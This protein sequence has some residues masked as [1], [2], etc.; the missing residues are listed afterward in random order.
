MTL[1]GTNSYLI[2]CGNGEAVCI[3]PGPADS[4]HVS[5]IV[6]R[7]QRM[8]CRIRTIA[9]THGH[10]DHAPAAP[11]LQSWTGASL[12]TGLHPI[13]AGDAVLEVA[14]AP[15]H[16]ADHVVYY[17]AREA[18]LFTGDTVLGTGYVVVAP[19]GGDMRAYQQTLEML[20]ERFEQAR[21]IYPGHGEP[22]HDPAGKLADYI[23]HRKKRERQI[24]DVL[25]QGPCTIPEIVET[26]YSDTAEVLWPVAA[27]QVLAYLIALQRESNVQ[28][29]ALDRRPTERETALLNPDWNAIAGKADRD[30]VRAELG[31]GLH[32][33]TIMRYSL[34]YA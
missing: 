9:V 1:S 21:T 22:V 17:E 27:R 11:I 15:G 29:Q 25:A 4:T 24:L 12:S 7:A 3:D 10:P 18:A 33:D 23:E 6:E 34:S 20:R 19:P 31:A 16:A 13:R 32:V 26:I 30:V 2:D 14:A 5:A 28:A 8:A